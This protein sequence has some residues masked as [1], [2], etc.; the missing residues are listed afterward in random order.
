[1]KF[2]QQYTTKTFSEHPGLITLSK[3]CD[4]LTFEILF[5]SGTQPTLDFGLSGGKFFFDGLRVA[6]RFARLLGK[7]DEAASWRTSWR[8]D[9]DDLHEDFPALRSGEGGGE[10]AVHAADRLRWVRYAV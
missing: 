1:M 7:D 5:G 9:G 6:E 2:Y 8:R 4:Y 10:G 3:W